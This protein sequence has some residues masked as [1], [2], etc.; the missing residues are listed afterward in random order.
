MSY[1]NDLNNRI[2]TINKG[3][4]E[5]YHEQNEA[6]GKLFVRKRLELLFDEGIEVEDAFFR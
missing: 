5:K 6:K 3:G 4:K 1:V 2:E